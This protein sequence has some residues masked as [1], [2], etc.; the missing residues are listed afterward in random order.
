MMTEIWCSDTVEGKTQEIL[1]P[2][3]VEQLLC[4]SSRSYTVDAEC[5]TDAFSGVLSL[6]Q[7][8]DTCPCS[9]SAHKGHPANVLAWTLSSEEGMNEKKIML[10]AK[11]A[12]FIKK[13]VTGVEVMVVD[14]ETLKAFDAFFLIDRRLAVCSLKAKNEV[15]AGSALGQD[16]NVLDVV[17]VYKGRDVAERVPALA[18]VAKFCVGMDMLSMQ[19]R[20]FFLFD[21]AIDKD[22]FFT[23]FKILRLSAELANAL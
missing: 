23:S 11:V 18:S 9:R 15:S 2:R 19:K 3:H 14:P 12:S 6:F 4:C 10:R 5:H 17:S 20:V 8:Q 7:Q 21:D 16:F 1:L 22:E 13:A